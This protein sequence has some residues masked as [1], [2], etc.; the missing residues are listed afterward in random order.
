[1]LIQELNELYVNAG[2]LFRLEGDVNIINNDNFFDLD[3]S[4]EGELAGPNDV[5]SVVNMYFSGTLTSGQA[6]LCG[7]TRFPPSSDRVFVA[8]GCAT[9]VG[10]TAH[11]LGHYFTLYH[12]HGRTNN[13]TTDELVARVDCESLGDE[14]CDTA[15][16]PNLSGKVDGGCNYIGGDVD[17][18]G[19]QFV[20]D[21]K[22]LMSYSLQSCR[23]LFT[24]SQYDRIRNGL[25]NGRDY[26]NIS[27]D[28]FRAS[29]TA[30][31][32]S[33]CAPLSV[34]FS[35]NTVTGNTRKWIFGGIDTE[36]FSDEPIAVFEE[37]GT[38]SV[39]LIATN[40][41]GDTDTLTRN[42]YITVRDRFE[43]VTDSALDENFA[44]SL[45]P[46][47]YSI[48]NI[49][50]LGF[51]EVSDVSNDSGTGSI[52]INGFNYDAFSFPQ[53]DLLEFPNFRIDEISSFNLSFS[54][55]YAYRS[56]EA[57][58]EIDPV[59]DSLGLYYSLGCESES[60]FLWK[61][62]G[63]ELSTAPPESEVAFV[64]IS[65]QWDVNTWE[66]DLQALDD[67]VEYDV[68]RFGFEAVVYG[69]NNLYI[70]NLIVQPRY[71][72]I[73]PGFLRETDVE[74]GGNIAITWF[75]ESINELGFI[76]ERSL[77]EG[78]F[79]EVARVERNERRYEEVRPE[80]QRV[81]YRVKAFN[82][83]SES[84]FTDILDV[85]TI[86]SL[87][88]AVS[89]A[90]EINVYPNP[91]SDRRELTLDIP[92]GEKYIYQLTNVYGSTIM[93]GTVN[94]NMNIISFLGRESGVY[95]ITLSNEFENKTFKI[96]V[97]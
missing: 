76:I 60:V 90:Q 51:F 91:L 17:A 11:E 63:S 41:V 64:P 85:G 83:F 46:D 22:N 80:A 33:G 25:E 65:N 6:S 44:G 45:F 2:I 74:F 4:E 75:E 48:I 40:S 29:F 12:T 94:N 26:L 36:S 21:P 14:I 54:H 20:P 37:P 73:A 81:R 42:N 43:N 96:L 77:D 1:E 49:D 79:A 16:D 7:Y 57:E 5:S 23:D 13:G 66:L 93:F 38:Y 39:T 19:Q 55:A 58:T 86:T 35:D 53:V 9:G 15:A 70:D 89:G 88:T 8:A 95:F 61:S 10:T 97:E 34:Q 31:I 56:G 24:P 28:G 71:D 72:L 27:S 47:D 87:N 3:S 67:I 62:G 52:F 92:P 69:G 84:E 59:Y 18:N 50:N 78:E 32:R 82:T 30:D 68:I